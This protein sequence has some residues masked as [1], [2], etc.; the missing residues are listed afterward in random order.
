MLEE[1]ELV[2][3]FNLQFFA[4]DGPGGAKTEP[5]SAK[6]LNEARQEGQVARSKDLVNAISLFAFFIMLK[7]YVG[8]LGT[9]LLGSFSEIYS[10]FPKIIGDKRIAPENNLMLAVIGEAIMDIVVMLL[11]ILFVGFLV[12]FL[13]NVIQFK[14]MITAKP[15]MPKLSKIDPFSGVK[16]L[17]SI[18]QLVELLKSI[19]MVVVIFFMVWDTVN[20]RY[21]LLYTLY[22]IPLERALV[23]I[24]EILIDLGIKISAIFLVIGVADFVFQKFKFKEDMM[25]TK[26][27]VKDEYKQSEGDPQIKGQI[28]RRM[29]EASRRRMMQALPEADVVIT[30][31]THFAVALK[32]DT[33]VSKAPVVIAKGAD[34][35]AFQIK[36]KA[37]EYKIDIV[38]NKPLARLLYNNVEVGAEI[39][40]ELYQA[41]A[42]VLAFVYSLHNKI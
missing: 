32:Y 25:M 17:F 10:L 27:E 34:Y 12:A 1:K 42:E 30:N 36:D 28:R 16:R 40:P 7:Q 37:K 29:Q 39:P 20:D 35:L 23:N 41:V 8:T 31:P 2:L 11:P 22:D 21:E 15:L 13:G 24:G 6:K 38:E 5:A 19:A 33:N 4:K 18:K 9:S 3:K 26:Q 14:W